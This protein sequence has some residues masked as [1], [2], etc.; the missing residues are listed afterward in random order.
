MTATTNDTS[1]LSSSILRNALLPDGRTV[2]IVVRD[3]LIE[4]VHAAGTVAAGTA[5]VDDL[6]GRIVLPSLAEP[7][8][9]LDKAL[10]ADMAPNLTGDLMGAIDA[11]VLAAS[12]GR[13][14]HDDC[15]RRTTRALRK[16]V[17]NGV[18][19]VRSHVNVGEG[20]GFDHLAAVQ[21]AAVPFEG[22]IDLQLVALTHYPVIGRDGAANRA[23]LAKAIDQGVHLVGGCPHLEPDGPASIQVFLDAAADAGVGVDLHTD[24]TLNPDMLT[25]RDLAHAV[26]DRGFQ[27]PVSASHCVSLSMQPLD[28]QHQVA[29]VVAEAGISVIPLPQ[30]NLFLQGHAHATAMPRGITPIRLLREAGVL[31]AAGGDNVQDPFN[32]VGRSDPLET[33]ALLIMTAHLLPEEAFGLVSNDVRRVMGLAPAD[34]AVGD[35]ADFLAI[36]APTVRGA[37]ADAPADRRVYRRGE[38]V[39]ATTSTSNVYPSL[40]A[41]RAAISTTTTRD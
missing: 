8:A 17:I 2:D 15:V 24:E 38:L 13:F 12:N 9:H 7:H 11:W 22:L 21:E 6:A 39:A 5:K 20:L 27:H 30:T 33:A 14:T 41:I 3:G 32:P 16:L 1:T 40:A 19:A 25:L 31:V 36:A 29:D 18:T 23:L 10:T 37:I 28:V 34:L 4:G 35:P 26:I